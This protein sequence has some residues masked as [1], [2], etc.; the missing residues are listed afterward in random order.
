[1]NG[2]IDSAAPENKSR[3]KK[4]AGFSAPSSQDEALPPHSIEAEQGLLGC[5]LLEPG[6]CIGECIEKFKRGSAVFYDL[7]HQTIYQCLVEMYD[8]GQPVDIITLQ[9][10]LKERQRL[11]EVGGLVYLNSLPDTVPSAA[12]LSY[13]ADIVLEKFILR[14]IV[15]T[16]TDVRSRVYESTAD[17]GTLLD[18]IEH[19]LMQLTEDRVQTREVTGI[20]IV[21]AAI[22]RIDHYERGGAQMLG[23]SY[24][25]DYLDKMTC[26]MAPGQMI[27]IAA[28]PGMGK[29]SIGMCM[30]E[31][32]AIDKKIP[33]GVF[34]LEM[35][36]Q[37]LGSRL[38][39]QRARSDYQRFRTGYFENGDMPRLTSAAKQIGTAPLYVDDTSG[40]SI[41]ELRSKARR[42][43]RQYGVKWFLID[44][45]QL[46]RPS[47]RY[48]NREQE[49]AE[50][51]SGLKAMAKELQ[52]P[53]VVLAQFNREIDKEPNRKPRLSDL[54]ESGSIEQDA[55]MVGMLYMPKLKDKEKE[56]LDQEDP[57]W[58]NKFSRVNLLIAK[59][60]SG[61]T[62]DVELEYHKKYM[63]FESFK[64]RR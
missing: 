39:F 33:T 29:T 46:M 23:L 6:E 45:L 62:G 30:V 27:V 7:R 60:R 31:H 54:R 40:L 11:E 26:G 34:S 47:R 59:Q 44:Y 8:A 42:M 43:V 18:T 19:D 37:E 22:D 48:Q 2:P 16:C 50:I 17:L 41:M 35:T 21:Q 4:R 64:R 20:E 15:Q 58:S 5:I 10:K 36:T 51:S 1:M 25:Y 56:A 63:R 12:N 9:E 13:Y 55:D 32:T 14:K 49:V 3:R 38:L 24:G 61:P 52:V 57:D 53:V 28:R